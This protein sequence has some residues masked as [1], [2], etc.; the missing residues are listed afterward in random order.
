MVMLFQP[1]ILR[2]GLLMAASIVVSKDSPS[3]RPSWLQQSIDAIIVARRRLKRKLCR[4]AQPQQ[5]CEVTCASATKPVHPHPHTQLVKRRRM[6]AAA[7]GTVAAAQ[8]ANHART[9]KPQICGCKSRM[10]GSSSGQ[11]PW[12]IDRRGWANGDDG[13]ARE[14]SNWPCRLPGNFWHESNGKV[15]L[16]LLLVR[17]QQAAYLQLVVRVETKLQS[18]VIPHIPASME[19]R[20]CGARLGQHPTSAWQALKRQS[21]CDCIVQAKEVGSLSLGSHRYSASPVTACGHSAFLRCSLELHLRGCPEE[22]SRSAVAHALTGIPAPPPLPT[23]ANMSPPADG[24][25]SPHFI[26]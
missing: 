9:W 13:R 7:D 1:V 17:P 2:P 20:S 4:T 12:Q 21:L 25:S 15:L 5:T 8:L 23:P 19:R 24:F 22:K 11:A 10:A 3:S 6:T 14:D 18:S 26:N 16:M